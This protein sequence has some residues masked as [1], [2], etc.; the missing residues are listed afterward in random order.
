[1]PPERPWHERRAR[2]IG[3]NLQQAC[4]GGLREMLEVSEHRASAGYYQAMEDWLRITKTE[5][6][7]ATHLRIGLVYEPLRGVM[8]MP[9]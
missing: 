6:A 3:H 4:T 9:K 5:T 7:T 2:L 1:M 8:R